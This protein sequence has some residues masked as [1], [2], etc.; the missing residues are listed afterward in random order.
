MGYESREYNKPAEIEYEGTLTKNR[1]QRPTCDQAFL[2]WC[3]ANAEK[4]TAYD[5]MGRK[6][7]LK[8]STFKRLM[9][10]HGIEL[11]FGTHSKMAPKPYQNY[12]WL[13]NQI[14]T[15]NKSIQQVAE[16]NGWTV[17][18][19]TKWTGLLGINYRT[20]KD[21]KK[22]S[23]KQ[24]DLIK[25]SLLG[26][27][28]ISKGYFIVSHSE[29]QKDYLYWKFEMLRDLCSQEPTRY[30]ESVKVIAG[31]EVHCEPYYRFNTRGLT[32]IQTIDKI[33]I[34]QIVE[35]L[36]D[37]GLS[38]WMLDDGSRDASWSLCVAAYSEEEKIH[39]VNYFHRRGILSAKIRPTETRYIVFNTDDSRTIDAIIL[40]NIPND[41][42]VIQY[43]I[44]N[45]PRIKSPRS[46]KNG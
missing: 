43:K 33:P 36:D 5:G 1:N 31:K 3:V 17:R 18:V 15:L 10:D 42:D 11:K 28:C 14:V 45:N 7:G 13:F 35:D 12:D 22:I 24:R 38:V 25:F 44:I 19:V 6:L 46:Q 37:F 41:L 30:E 8:G 21:L 39:M 26:D 29:R 2:D 4:F 32:E 40:Q 27:G 9:Q 16:E 20:F 34:K 23:D